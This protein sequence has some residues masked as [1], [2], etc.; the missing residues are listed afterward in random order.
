MDRRRRNMF[1]KKK[2]GSDFEEYQGFASGEGYERLFPE[3]GASEADYESVE[4][5]YDEEPEKM[6]MTRMNMRNRRKN[7]NPAAFS[8]RKPG[9]RILLSAYC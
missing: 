2:R 6:N 8:A 9:S 4:D 1:G 3:E 5:G 7:R